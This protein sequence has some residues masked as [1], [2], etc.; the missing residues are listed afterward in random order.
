MNHDLRSDGGMQL[1]NVYVHDGSGFTQGDV[2][3][4]D[5]SD[6]VAATVSA[7]VRGSEFIFVGAN[8]MAAIIRHVD[9]GD[10]PW[11][12]AADE[13]LADADAAVSAG[14]RSV[15]DNGGACDVDEK[16][17]KDPSY[18]ATDISSGGSRHDYR[19][20]IDMSRWIRDAAIGYRLTGD[21]RYAEAAIDKLQHWFVGDSS[22]MHPTPWNRG[23]HVCGATPQGGDIEQNITIPAIWYGAAMVWN[24][25]YWDSAHAGAKNEILDWIPDYVEHQFNTFPVNAQNYGAW[26]LAS[27]AVASAFMEAYGPDGWEQTSDLIPSDPLGATFDEWRSTISDAVDA[28]G[29]MV[30]EISRGSALHYSLYGLKAY[31]M[32]AEVARHHDVDLYRYSDS[33]GGVLERA[34]DRHVPYLLGEEDWPYGK[35]KEGRLN[36][37]EPPALYELAYNVFGKAD[38]LEVVKSPNSDGFPDL[39]GGRPVWDRRLLGWVSLSHGSR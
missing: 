31:V 4:H 5:G 7:V 11:V 8:E 22:H 26:R 24:H 21:D 19:A 27:C 25:D 18:W 16:S 38:Y 14:P 9:A 35:N 39:D 20:A 6:F 13:L 10:D 34:L 30:E 28:E 37:E 29:F 32:T 12:S 3:V 23:P 15:W 1:S 17:W 36:S 2:F 33:D